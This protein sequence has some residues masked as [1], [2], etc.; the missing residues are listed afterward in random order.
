M[1]GTKF[2]F[3]LKS[4]SWVMIEI[5]IHNPSDTRDGLIFSF[6]FLTKF[7]FYQQEEVKENKQAAQHYSSI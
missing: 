3:F 6:P 2:F 7:S 5:T 1:V 4:L